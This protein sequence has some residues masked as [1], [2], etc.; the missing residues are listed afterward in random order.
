[1]SS[2]PKRHALTPPVNAPLIE[3]LEPRVLLS[4]TPSGATPAF[5]DNLP[6][7]ET[8][9]SLPNGTDVDTGD[10]AWSIDRSNA[11][12]TALIAVSNG[13]FRAQGTG[14]E[15]VW[16]S[17]TL[18]IS[19]R[20][21]VDLS[22]DLDGAGTLENAGDFLDY[23]RVYAVIDGG[24][25]QLLAERVGNINN[26][27]PETLTV[28]GLAG[29][30]LQ[31]VIRTLTTGAT[32]AYLWDNLTLTPNPDD[33][34]P[35]P[36]PPTGDELPWTETFGGLPNGT[37]TDTGTTAWTTDGSNLGGSAQVGVSN[38][39]FRAQG[40]G[41]E[42]VWLSE[43]LD[44]SQRTGV[45]LSLD[46]DGAGT[47]EN[48]G[49]FLDYLRV[50]AIIDGGPE[51]LLAERLGNVN[52]GQPETLTVN[53]LAGSTLQ[54]VIR[55]LTTGSTEAYLWDNLTLTPNPD[56]PPPPPPNNDPIANNDSATVNENGSILIPVLSNDTDPDNDTLAITGVTVDPTQGQATVEGNAIR[57]TPDTD[58]N[59]SDTFTYAISDG[60]GGNAS[61]TVAL[62]IT[63]APPP[64]PPP[65]P[66]GLPWSETFAGL[67]N[68]TTTDTGDTAWSVDDSQAGG[69]ATIGVDGGWFA[70]RNTDG[71]VTW[72]SE[73]IDFGGAA[74][75]DLTL[76]IQGLGGLDSSGRFA[77]ALRVY[78]R[79]DGGPETLIAERLGRFNSSNPQTL[80]VDG[81][82]G[83]SL[84]VIVRASNTANN[85]TYRW[86]NLTVTTVVPPP[87]PDPQPGTLALASSQFAVNEDAGVV[88][89]G[90]T[91]TGGSDGVVS[92]DYLTAEGSA[93]AGDDF[94][95]V[96]GTLVFA[97]GQTFASF[98]VPILQDTDFET[99]ETFAVSLNRVGGEANLAQPRTATVT[100]AD[101]DTDTPT[102]GTGD[103]LAAVYFDQ[104][105]FAGPS[106]TRIDP[107]VNFD[108]ASGSPDP[109]IGNN[110]FSA[111][112]TG[113]IEALY[114]ERY[115][116]TTTAD[117]G[118]RL[119]V[120]DQLIIDRWNDQTATSF[121]GTIDLTAGQRVN[122]RL[123]YY[124]NGG[125]AVAQ[126]AWQS[127][128]QAF[129][130]VPTS[131]L[132]STGYTGDVDP[133]TSLNLSAETIITGLNQPTALSFLPN[134]TALVAQKNGVVR[135]YQNGQL[136]S[137]PFI[138][139]SEEVNGVRDRGLLGLAVHPDFDNNPYVYLLYT[140]DPPE[141]QGQAG[142]AGPDGR[143]S[144]VSR[145]LRVTA[146]PA[147]DFA[148]AIANSGVVIL[149]TN[150]TYENI[151]APDRGQSINNPYGG[152]DENGN[153]IQDVLPIDSESHT[154]GG[155][156]FLP[157]GSLIVSSGDGT[158][159]GAVDPQSSRVQD[160]DSL[161]GKILRID[162]ITGDGLADNPFYTGDPD[163]NASKV[164]ALG[165][166]NPFRIAVNP[167]NGKLYVGDVGWTRW[168]EVNEV[169]R[170]GNY[171]WPW[172]EGGNGA[173]IQT[174]G[175]RDLQ[176]AQDFYAAGTPVEPSLFARSHSDGGVAVVVG[177]V[178]TG[179]VYDSSYDN[180]LFFTDYGTGAIEALVF[181]DAGG[182]VGVNTVTDRIGVVVEMTM[183][184]DG[185]MW[186]VDITGSV[187]RLV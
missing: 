66:S 40:T 81:I 2:P 184:P 18:D 158:S 181:D 147:T 142:F 26:G 182:L 38:G 136:L 92:I 163:A 120:D 107:D 99:E 128:S 176:D 88:T 89:I 74:T 15:A 86:D 187:G 157:D 159:Y 180:A 96:S 170:G 123:E 69:G 56:D 122:L 137:T 133:P 39:T 19:Q 35:P 131:Q 146:D 22:L 126:L 61:A 43:T 177:D 169:V 130:I 90:V 21:G 127:A 179:T 42:A 167:T 62:T 41:G 98:D 27:Q 53:D 95:P 37:T 46:L 68:G 17:D 148:T 13:A 139:L 55:T 4:A 44:I 1:M 140:Y 31:I 51:Q 118:I 50:Y 34:P 149:G 36:P 30:T 168:E 77:D 82:T 49:D 114:S 186:Y 108:W 63:P 6:W 110:T 10:T 32:E 48:A 103:G 76:D 47:L 20:T 106:V 16:C 94:T 116:F 152:L 60:N 71:L 3:S 135:A 143:G 83:S 175:Y 121:T 164:W 117:D 28:N 93:T 91:R 129:E 54:I 160:L 154:I 97:D 144:R 185:T 166:R 150:S 105:G 73:V 33:P 104:L 153:Y 70:V 165:F 14:G 65:P 119:W 72:S 141:T 132:Y 155:L 64:P 9:E 172:F 67:P 8:F 174:N 12:P 78:T 11:R 115:T 25:E 57:Y 111:R 84:Q 124:E 134:G 7:A 75:V 23:L 151:G 156:A 102:P 58:T 171:G 87:P 125:A 138:D 24:P 5:T 59:G 85:E 79:V 52:N 45:D 112:W 183:G 162:P 101:D 100:L 113:Q 178:Y 161:N 80:T 109:A 145:L 29:S 173:P